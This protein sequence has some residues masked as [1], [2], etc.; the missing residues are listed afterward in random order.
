MI[1]LWITS[2]DMWKTL[3]T[4]HGLMMIFLFYFSS[5]HSAET[6]RGNWVQ[7][8]IISHKNS[9]ES[10]STTGTSCFSSNCMTLQS[11]EKANCSKASVP[12]RGYS[13]RSALLYFPFCSTGPSTEYPSVSIQFK[14]VSSSACHASLLSLSGS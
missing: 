12:Y 6:G 10:S 5:I 2:I 4:V 7:A 9:P 8:H 11:V 13:E 14:M 3:Q 1:I